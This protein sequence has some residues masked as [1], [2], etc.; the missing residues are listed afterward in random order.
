MKKTLITLISALCI[1]ATSATMAVAT[2]TAPKSAARSNVTS[3]SFASSGFP[4]TCPPAAVVGRSLG[5]SLSRPVATKEPGTPY[6]LL[7]CIYS[8]TPAIARNP[9]IEW[10]KETPA[11]FSA[12]EKTA[13][14]TEH[15]VAV[16]NLGKGV[17][18][19]RVPY[20][21]LNAAFYSPCTF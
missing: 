1:V 10:Q 18:A 21:A 4:T 20:T 11:A 3:I 19:Y 12:A 15:A 6:W 2:T 5:L 8:A 17:A 7:N 16:A 9:V 14:K 13:I